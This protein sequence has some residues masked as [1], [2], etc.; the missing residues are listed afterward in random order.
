MPLY[1]YR[2]SQCGNTFEMLRRMQEAD[3]DLTCPSCESEKVE[4]LIST[5]ARTSAG[6]PSSGCG[7]GG[8]RFT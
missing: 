5:F 1:E 3:Q 4:R 2:C 6:S 7:G 8:R